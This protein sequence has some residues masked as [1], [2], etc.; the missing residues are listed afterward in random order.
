MNGHLEKNSLLEG[1]IGDGLLGLQRASQS[2]YLKLRQEGS[3]SRVVST[4][5]LGDP[6]AV[7]LLMLNCFAAC[8]GINPASLRGRAAEAISRS[9]GPA[10][11]FNR[12]FRDGS[13]SS[14]DLLIVP[15]FVSIL[16]TVSRW[17]VVFLGTQWC[18][19]Q[20]HAA[21][22]NF[23]YRPCDDAPAPV[24]LQERSGCE[25]KKASTPAAETR[26]QVDVQAP[27]V[28]Y[29]GYLFVCGTVERAVYAA[30][31]A[32]EGIVVYLD[33]VFEVGCPEG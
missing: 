33:D 4:R 26:E 2:F 25:D 21:W 1:V 13:L 3:A 8:P 18:S 19:A 5:R 12:P 23:R 30:V 14:S 22:S 32:G 29:P 10:R 16:Q 27:V 6:V 9:S 31:H 15:L 7:A 28:E 24:Q 20:P 11:L 17:V